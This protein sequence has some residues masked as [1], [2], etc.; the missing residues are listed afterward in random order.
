MTWAVFSIALTLG[1]SLE[2]GSPNVNSWTFAR[3]SF[4]HIG[5]FA[6]TFAGVGSK[7]ASD[8]FASI[9]NLKRTSTPRGPAITGGMIGLS[10]ENGGDGCTAGFGTG[11]STVEN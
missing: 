10:F 1:N 9:L 8:A 11:A 6:D 2:I 5:N 3:S 7:S 4:V